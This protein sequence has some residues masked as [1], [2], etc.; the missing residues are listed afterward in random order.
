MIKKTLLTLLVFT[1]IFVQAQARYEIKSGRIVMT[2][3]V[4]AMEQKMVITFDD[5]GATELTDITGEIM[6]ITT[7]SLQLRKDGYY[8][9][10]DLN[11]RTGKKSRIQEEGTPQNI[12]FS[13]L[14]E[15]IINDLKLEKTG[16]EDFMGKTCDVWE[17]N[18]PD[19]R[20]TG[21]YLVWKGISLKTEMSIS[22]MPI[23][24]TTNEIE[25]DIIIEPQTFNIP[26][27]ISIVEE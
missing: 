24:M 2:S 12:N 19:M 9:T 22:G 3:Q 10:I 8:Y 4:F 16:T 15:R 7:H 23:K 27:D 18:H 26:A 11:N 13:N 21:K 20:M 17:M 1:T 14:S 25:T 6:G 5:Y